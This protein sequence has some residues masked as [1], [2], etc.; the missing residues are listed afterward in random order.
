MS[1][2][3]SRCALVLFCFSAALS[4]IVGCSSSSTAPAGGP[5]AMKLA[6]GKELSAEG[7]KLTV[8]GVPFAEVFTN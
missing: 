8:T 6:D 7:A 3:R 4:G 2:L 5:R 1:I